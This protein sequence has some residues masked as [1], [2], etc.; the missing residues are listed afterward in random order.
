MPHKRVC[1]EVAVFHFFDEST[2][3][4]VG[5]LASLAR[6]PHRLLDQHEALGKQAQAGVAAHV[7]FQLLAN[8]GG[9]FQ[10]LIDE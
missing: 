6:Q 9:H 2:E 7:D 4:G 5:G 3:R 8:P 10:P 1:N